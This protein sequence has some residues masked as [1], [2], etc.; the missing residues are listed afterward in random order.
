M[1]KIVLIGANH[2]GIAAANTILDSYPENEVVIIDKNT[3]LSY[4]GCGTALWVG[5][6]ID[7]YEHLFYTNKEAFEEKGARILMEATVESIDFDNKLIHA[8]RANGEKF[9]ESY[10]KVILATGS[11]P[12]APNIKGTDLENVQFVKLFQDSQVAD[13]ALCEDSIKEVSVI[14][15]GYIGVEMAE[16][17]KRRGKNVRLFDAAD[18]SLNTYYD[19]WFTEDMDNVLTE[20]GIQTHYGEMVQSFEGKDGKVTNLTTD[21]GTYKTDLVIMAIGFAP[22]NSLGKDKLETFDNGAYL[23]NLKQETSLPDVYAVGDCA[24]IYSNAIEDT[25]YIALAT[26]AVRSGIVGGHNAAGTP[27]ESIGVQGSNGISIFGY[28]MVSTGLNLAAAKEAGYEVKYTDFEDL[29]KPGFIEKNGNVKIRIVYDAKTRR[30][31][32]AQ[33]ASTEDISMG[34]HMFSLAIEEKVT[35]DK[36]KLLDIFFLPHFN[37]PYNYITMAALSAE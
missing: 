33:M 31:L 7:S 34:I 8:T 13:K 18:T 28:N 32:G 22:N 2:A 27:L 3:N 12:I 14:G 6:H 35:I 17:V 11:V 4:L 23:V 30:V 26:N 25:T 20:N 9:E 16:A 19:P 36:L 37:Q 5:R 21:K 29:Q 24:T 1:S 10:D 15:A